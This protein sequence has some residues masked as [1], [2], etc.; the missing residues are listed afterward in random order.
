[1]VKLALHDRTGTDALPL[2]RAQVARLLPVAADLDDSLRTA[3]GFDRTLLLWRRAAMTATMRFLTD[4]TAA[5]HGY[6]ARAR[7]REISPVQRR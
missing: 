4:L 1:M 3:A 6:Q 5:R 2:V 7:S